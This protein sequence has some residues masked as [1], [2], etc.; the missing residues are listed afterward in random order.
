MNRVNG[1]DNNNM[2]SCWLFIDDSILNYLLPGYLL[3]QKICPDMF[4]PK[5][6]N[7]GIESLL[8]A[9]AV[10]LVSKSINKNWF[11]RPEP[12]SALTSVNVP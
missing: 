3:H 2:E 9:D 8:W 4:Q 11:S 12:D 7:V 1:R 5:Y 6:S 10:R